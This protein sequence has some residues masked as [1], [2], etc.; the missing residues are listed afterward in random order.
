MNDATVRLRD[1]VFDKGQKLKK[2]GLGN[3]F[4]P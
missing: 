1:K 2:S 4:A 3:L